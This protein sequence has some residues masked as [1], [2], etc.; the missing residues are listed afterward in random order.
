MVWNRGEDEGRVKT[1]TGA[2]T[3]PACWIIEVD[4]SSKRP[5]IYA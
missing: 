5:Q 1:G 2:P 4:I 3:V